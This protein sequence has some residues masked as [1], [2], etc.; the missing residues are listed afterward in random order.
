MKM[1]LFEKKKAKILFNFGIFIILGDRSFLA[2]GF[3]NV[4]EYID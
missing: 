1:L 4:I 2:L 3:E